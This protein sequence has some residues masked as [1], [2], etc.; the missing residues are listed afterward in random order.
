MSGQDGG[1]SRGQRVSK[2]PSAKPVNNAVPWSTLLRYGADAR[3]PYRPRDPLHDRRS[4]SHQEAAH[5]TVPDH[6][7]H[8]EPNVCLLLK[9]EVHIRSVWKLSRGPSTQLPPL[10][11]LYPMPLSHSRVRKVYVVQW[12]LA[13]TTGSNP[14]TSKRTDKRKILGWILMRWKRSCCQSMETSIKIGVIGM[15][16]NPRDGNLLDIEQSMGNPPAQEVKSSFFCKG[17]SPRDC[18]PVKA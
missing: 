13:G 3:K 18:Q 9:G 17:S 8:P 15:Q 7:T 16:G 2:T 14:C 1:Q 12:C 10:E 4:R 11:S 6:L 5:T